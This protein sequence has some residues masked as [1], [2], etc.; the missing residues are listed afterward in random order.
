[1][2]SFVAEPAALKLRE[3]DAGGAQLILCDRPDT[4]GVMQSPYEI[5]AVSGADSL[6]AALS[7]A[8][9]V[10]RVVETT[11]TLSRTITAFAPSNLTNATAELLTPLASATCA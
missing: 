5:R 7:S 3:A 9:G 6:R 4:P 10:T 11:R 2:R 1:M 8:L